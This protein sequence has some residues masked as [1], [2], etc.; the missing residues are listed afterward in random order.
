MK[1]REARKK[2]ILYFEGQEAR[3][4][5]LVR[6]NMYNPFIVDGKID[7]DKVLE[8]L[9]QFNEFINHSRR[10]FTPIITFD[11]KL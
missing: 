2:N 7:T 9:C 4:F 8:F 5:E 3:A 11:L 10:P 1:I 6:K